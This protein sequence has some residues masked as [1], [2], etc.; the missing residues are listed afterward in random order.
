MR[1]W[2]KW[3]EHLATDQG[4]G[5]SSPPGRTIDLRFIIYDFRL[6]IE[7]NHCNLKS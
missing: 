4:T 1:P 7:K 3:I 2:L 5:G 6:K